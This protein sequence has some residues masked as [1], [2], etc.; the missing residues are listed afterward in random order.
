[1]EKKKI[2]LI[3]GHGGKDKGAYNKTTKETETKIKG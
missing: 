2:C 1:M 3:V